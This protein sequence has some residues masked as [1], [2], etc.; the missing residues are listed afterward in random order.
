MR[1]GSIDREA[2]DIL[3]ERRPDEL[4]TLAS[5]HTENE[6]T[7]LARYLTGLPKEPRERVLG[8][9][10]ADA[11]VMKVLASDRV[12]GGILSSGTPPRPS[13]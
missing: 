10:I 3:F 7:A 11:S 2:R 5:A 9:V 8:A 1:L 13:I 6:L 4:K 12:H